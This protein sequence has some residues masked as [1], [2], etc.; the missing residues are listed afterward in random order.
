MCKKTNIDSF[1]GEAI[2]RAVYS[3]Y[4]TDFVPSVNDIRKFLQENDIFRGSKWSLQ[5]TLKKLNFKYVK[6]NFNRL[7][8]MEKS[9]IINSRFH[10]LRRINEL[11]N[12]GRPII[13]LDETWV[14]VNYTKG[15][16]WVCE[17]QD[18][19]ID[20]PLNVPLGKGQRFIV[21]HAGSCVGFMKDT[22]K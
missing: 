9:H 14:N 12:L 16:V 21:V 5:Q 13:Y 20:P 17:K 6:N 18:G 15:K 8:L 10:F 22:F 4:K 19:S 7:F 3:L 11:R 2:K 1:T